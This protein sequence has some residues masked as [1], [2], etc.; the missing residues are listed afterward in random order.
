M[1][2]PTLSEHQRRG[3]KPVPRDRGLVEPFDLP[4]PGYRRRSKPLIAA[5]K[6]I[7]FTAGIELMLSADVVV[8]ADDCRFAQME[9]GRGVMAACGATLRMAQRAGAGNALQILLSGNEFDS[10]EALR[11]NFVQKI[12]PPGNEMQEALAIGQRIARQA[13]LAVVA[14]RLNVLKAIEEGPL[15]AAA[16]LLEVQEMLSH[17]EDAKEGRASFVERRPPVFGGR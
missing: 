12:T 17:S 5:V 1:D 4:L 16:H 13:P 6:G 10:Q 15:A 8:A 3:E 9:V 14:T 11:F 2:L 7:C